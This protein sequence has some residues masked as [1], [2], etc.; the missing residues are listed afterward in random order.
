MVSRSY[1][2]IGTAGR[3]SKMNEVNGLT[4]VCVFPLKETTNEGPTAFLQ[5]W[6]VRTKK[7]ANAVNLLIYEDFL[8]G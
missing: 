2:S 3:Q 6:L 8:A 4:R 5:N 1:K 7:S